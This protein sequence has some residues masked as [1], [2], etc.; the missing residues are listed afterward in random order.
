[1]KN[2]TMIK[3]SFMKIVL[4]YISTNSTSYMLKK[5]CE[6]L[7]NTINNKMEEI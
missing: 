6:F 7:I 5:D 1:M 4:T 3:L 2:I